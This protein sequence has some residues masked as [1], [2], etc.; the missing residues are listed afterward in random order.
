ALPDLALH[1]DAPAHH[2]DKLP[3]DGQAQAGAAHL[4]RRRAVHL[5]E[6]LEQLVHILA[7]D[8]DTGVDHV[9]LHARR[10]AGLRAIGTAARPY[11]NAALVCELGRVGNEVQQ[12]LTHAHRV[13]VDLR[14]PFFHITDD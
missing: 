12:H 4:P 5:A 14:Q 9:D 6:G 1:P 8:T 13:A 2:L 11:G 3:R 7:G 10:L